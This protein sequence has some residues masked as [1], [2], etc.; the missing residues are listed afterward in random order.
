MMASSEAVN[1]TDLAIDHV[2]MYVDDL[3]T[4]TAG[5]V[6]RYAFRV[7]GERSSAEEGFRSVALRH[8]RVT[9]VLTE[10]TSDQHPASEY[11]LTHGDGVADIA[12]RTADVAVVFEAAVANGARPVHG[13]TRHGSGVTATISG[14]GDVT[15]TLVQRAAGEDAVLPPGFTP[16]AADERANDVRLKEIDH[17]AVCLNVGNLASTVEY[18]EKALG[19]RETF[20]EHIVVGSQAMNSKVV[21]SASGEVT[22]TLIE[23]DTT[24]GPGQIDDFLKN[25]QGE[26][27][28]HL[29]FS[30]DNAVRS[31]RNL[32]ARGVGF[33][34]TPG[35]Y[36]D[37]LGERIE[38][39]DHSLDELRETNL[40][41][42]EDHG[43]QLFQIF[44]S[45]TNQRR[46]IFYEVI[47]RRGAESFGSANIKALYEAVE[48]G[49]VK[50]AGRSR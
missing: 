43:G 5:W 36:Y 6:D 20:E 35:E 38:L 44:T 16:V 32:S 30:T 27:V 45:S 23:P 21:Q 33:L 22:Y 8:G 50:E 37:L 42:D 41:A 13:I 47:E 12:L 19:F 39:R 26:G 3:A 1:S 29:A 40:L 15:H 48:L 7:I 25:H 2:E 46:T 4:K 34:T 11:V 9:L 17:V 49:R 10:A 31:V 18:Y 28:Q 14:F 24:M